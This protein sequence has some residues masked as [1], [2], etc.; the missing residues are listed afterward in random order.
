MSTTPKWAIPYPQGTDSPD[1]PL[2]ME[3]M[4]TVLDDVAMDTA[5]V[6]A[7]RPA[8]GTSGRYYYATDDTSTGP[9]GTLF[10]DNGSAWERVGNQQVPQVRL[11]KNATQ[12]I[13]NGAQTAVLWQVESYDLGTPSLNM[14][15]TSTNTSRMTIRTA[16]TYLLVFNVEWTV[17]QNAG[18]SYLGFTL[19]GASVPFALTYG[20]PGPYASVSHVA[21]FAASDYIEAVVLQTAFTPATLGA[22]ATNANTLSATFLSV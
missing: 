10:R 16:G 21:R 4:A 22:G 9:T 14:H 12:S 20:P 6:V 5:G 7:S 13:N 19:N 1:V 2:W 15:D 17:A 8:A 3:D 18:T 11:T